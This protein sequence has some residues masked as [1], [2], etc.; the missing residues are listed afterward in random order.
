[1]KLGLPGPLDL[2]AEIEPAADGKKRKAR[3]PLEERALNTIQKSA[4][5]KRQR[6][7]ARKVARDEDGSYDVEVFT[8]ALAE[9]ASG[10]KKGSGKKA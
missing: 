4:E 10:G 9:Q 8:K 1:M 5:E 7:K 6:N 2:S 3:Q